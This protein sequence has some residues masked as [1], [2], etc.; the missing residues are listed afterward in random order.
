VGVCYSHNMARPKVKYA[1][2]RAANYSARGMRKDRGLQAYEYK[3]TFC[4]SWHVGVL[5]EQDLKYLAKRRSEK[6]VDRL[7]GILA[8]MI[9][10]RYKGGYDFERK[11]RYE[12]NHKR[13]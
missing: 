9:T 12:S 7:A 3:C 4:K 13:G 6:K 8:A 1:N 2:R 11:N 10:G 5:T